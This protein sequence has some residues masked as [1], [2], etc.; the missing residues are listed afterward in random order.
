MFGSGR[1]HTIS[2]TSTEYSSIVTALS[3][4]PR[5]YKQSSVAKTSNLACAHLGDRAHHLDEGRGSDCNLT[6]LDSLR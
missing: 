6:T 3:N 1:R 4:G 5:L 2:N